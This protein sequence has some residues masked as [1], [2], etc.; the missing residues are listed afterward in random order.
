M[1]KGAEDQRYTDMRNEWGEKAN[2]HVPTSKS[3]FQPLILQFVQIPILVAMVGTGEG[4]G[5]LSWV[6][7]TRLRTY[8]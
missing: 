3:S 5:M 8:L 7:L 1:K 2:L 6:D 4:P